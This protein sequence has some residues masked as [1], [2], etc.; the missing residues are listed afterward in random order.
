MPTLTLF[1]ALDMRT[2][3][4]DI[5]DTDA[6][7]DNLVTTSNGYLFDMDGGLSG[8]V[9]RFGPT[10][11][12]IYRVE[13]RDSANTLVA[14][15]QG[16]GP[17]FFDDGFNIE[18]LLPFDP[19]RPTYESTDP[20][21]TIVAFGSADDGL[22]GLGDLRGQAGDDI[23]FLTDFEDLNPA[24]RSFALGNNGDDI[25]IHDVRRGVLNGGNG[26]DFLQV[27]EGNATL[28]GGAGSDQFYFDNNNFFG[29]SSDGRTYARIRDFSVTE[30]QIGFAELR[31]LVFDPSAVPPETTS[32]EDLFGTSDLST[33][34]RET[35][36]TSTFFFSERDNGDAFIR[37]RGTDQFGDDYFENL[38][39]EGVGL[40]ELDASQVVFILYDE[41]G[42]GGA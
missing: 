33:L 37:R 5:D 16:D 10:G 35:V 31:D 11:T 40:D 21:A 15:I 28:I 13:I 2:L 6:T 34:S 8:T 12:D 22:V 9:E 36:G 39:I 41:A 17:L 7:T 26:D 20:G 38:T 1:A 18:A 14:M 27:W 30:D 29:G 19:I 23:I 24:Q 32:F 25:L 42:G 4:A 3:V